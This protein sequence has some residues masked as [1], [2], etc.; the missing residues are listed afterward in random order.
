MGEL[1]V[2]EASNAELGASAEAKAGAGSDGEGTVRSDSRMYLDQARDAK[3]SLP[4]L[5]DGL[6][7]IGP[8]ADRI[9]RD[10]A[11]A[12][13]EPEDLKISLADAI[14]SHSPWHLNPSPTPS[15]NFL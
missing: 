10:D 1:A 5:G 6:S 12:S 11:E 3:T 13:D 8:D 14:G 9:A 2:G 15:L 4:G 7:G